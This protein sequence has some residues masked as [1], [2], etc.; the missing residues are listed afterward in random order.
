[1]VFR[2]VSLG[3]RLWQKIILKPGENKLVRIEAP[4]TEEIS[5]LTIVKLLD[6][7]TQSVIMLK[8]KFL[9]NTAMSPGNEMVITLVSNARCR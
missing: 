6:K 8:V 7:L 5:S 9:R 1:M 4:F 3:F 2:L